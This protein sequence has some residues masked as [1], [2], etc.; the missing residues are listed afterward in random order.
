VQAAHNADLLVHEATFGTEEAARARETLHSTAADAAEVAKLA[1]VKLLA[2]THVSTRYFGSELAG[3]AR[4]V[5]ANT[6][7]PRDFDVIEVPFPERGDPQLV[8]AGA[9][10]VSSAG[11]GEDGAGGG[12]G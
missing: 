9:R 1:D 3:E 2:L 11:N 6:V 7:V 4:E 10:P 8:K 5:F 12:G